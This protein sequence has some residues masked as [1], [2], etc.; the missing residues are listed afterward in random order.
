MKG[1]LWGTKPLAS[2]TIHWVVSL[3][4]SWYP[5]SQMIHACRKKRGEKSSMFKKQI[6]TCV[7]T[8]PCNGLQ[9]DILKS[10][11]LTHAISWEISWLPEW[12]LVEAL[13]QVHHIRVSSTNS[14]RTGCRFYCS[15]AMA[16]VGR[17]MCWWHSSR[18]KSISGHSQ[19]PWLGN[20]LCF[21]NGLSLPT[22]YFKGQW[23]NNLGF[24]PFLL[25]KPG[26]WA[27]TISHGLEQVH[28][29]PFDTPGNAHRTLVVFNGK[30]QTHYML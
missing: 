19:S 15:I 28:G 17:V 2:V 10:P 29:C 7:T 8:F 26:S 13:Q 22:G 3:I 18:L 21:H 12:N 30:C 27:V 11:F 23:Q 20:H 4:K 1:V 5:R 6:W 9:D 16:N 14:R 25:T 24:M